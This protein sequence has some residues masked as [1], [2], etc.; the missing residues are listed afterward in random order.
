MVNGPDLFVYLSTDKSASDFVNL[1]RLDKFK[2]E[3]IYEISN[4]IDLT[5]YNKVL[6]WCKSF[7]VLFGSAELS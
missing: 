5:K 3:Q 7:G 4:K 1:N 2:G 6:V